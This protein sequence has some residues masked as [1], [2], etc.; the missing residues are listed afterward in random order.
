MNPRAVLYA[1]VKVVAL[2]AL[3]TAALPLTTPKT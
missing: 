3:L 2:S 1:P